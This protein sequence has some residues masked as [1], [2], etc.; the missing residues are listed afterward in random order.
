MRLPQSRRINSDVNR[1]NDLTLIAE[2]SVGPEYLLVE[3][4]ERLLRG[5]LLGQL[6]VITNFAIYYSLFSP[7]A[8]VLAGI[9]GM[10]QGRSIYS[11]AVAI[12]Q[13]IAGVL[14]EK[15]PVRTILIMVFIVRALIWGLLLPAS[16]I[17]APSGLLVAIFLVC[18]LIDG[19]VV[20]IGSLVDI[21]EGGI[22]LLGQQYGFS[23]DDELRNRFNSLYEGFASLSRIVVAPLMASLGIL[24]ATALPTAEDAIVLV[25]ALGFALPSIIGC[26][27]YAKYL[28]KDAAMPKG[29]VSGNLV[30]EVSSI[31]R[32][33]VAAIAMAWNIKPVRWRI[34][35]NSA[36]R[37]IE[38]SVILILLAAF[39]IQVLAPGDLARGAF[40]T[41][42]LIAVGKTG[43]IISAWAMH[44]Y[45]KAPAVD[46]EK[47]ASYRIF[48]PLAFAGTL[49]ILLLPIAV[50]FG[51]NGDTSAS[52]VLAC[53]AS[54]LF[55]LFFTAS[56][57]GF[58]NLMQ[59]IVSE[60]GASGRLFGIQGLFMMG[61][62]AVAV[63]FLS[64][65]F[66]VFNLFV[67][68][69]TAAIL[70]SLY[71]LLQLLLGRRLLFSEYS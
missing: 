23:V 64:V 46:S 41:A 1:M 11:G 47:W 6:A 45:W 54:L 28:P 30:S 9:G 2:S 15:I 17:L 40:Y 52:A 43:S 58:R 12:F 4:R 35:L 68:F 25:M 37:A 3:E 42:L 61:T 70:F 59:G 29:K 71:G 38:D 7:V 16:Y 33:L 32:D 62:S 44:R 67:A 63:L 34:L 57:L 36:E 60:V 24:L 48:F 18:M 49:S 65:V 55:N 39:A 51:L 31:Y 56:A 10:G 26:Y 13:P 66:S 14:A 5:Y 21:D 69:L 22:D 27:F 50:N 53:A 20:S 8:A 19:M